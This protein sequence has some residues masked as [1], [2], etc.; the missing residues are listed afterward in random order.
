[1]KI[2]IVNTGYLSVPPKSAGPLVGGSIEL[3]TYHLVNE[4]ANLGNEVH[5]VTN[6]NENAFFVDGVTLH[7]IPDLSP[8][9][10]KGDY[11]KTL[12]S[13]A[14][15]GC[16]AYETA[17]RAINAHRYD[18]IHVHGNISGA[19]LP[20]LRKRIK[21]VF[22]IHNRTPWMLPYSSL[23]QAFRKIAFNT[24]DL[25]IIC[26]ADRV[27]TLSE[28]LKREIVC[29]FKICPAKIKVIPNGVDSKFF[30]P[31][32]PNSASIRDKYEINH[33]YVLFVGR[34]VEEKAVHTLLE[35]IAGTNLHAVIVGD[36]PLL[37]F[38]RSLATH[39]RI[40]HQVNFI[41]LVP[42]S[43]LPNFYAQAALFVLPSIA[44]GSPLAGFEAM[45]SGLP[46]V[47]SRTSGMEDIV[48]ASQNGIIID[49]KDTQHFREK[50]VELF[51]NTSLRRIMGE[52]SRKIVE[53][54]YSWK[55]NARRTL[56]LYKTID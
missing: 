11:T 30:K 41:G 8:L 48:N 44:E 39:L 21:C 13:F 53:A 33:D 14:I 55:E 47:A 2:L 31:S 18:L 37:P 15:G 25:N 23:K 43:E 46:I 27:I 49:P 9:S 45:A 38:L 54:Q 34:L 56:E 36:G 10:T 6:I 26:S 22:T 20:L 29:R 32:I 35:A 5:Y 12:V 42:R 52:R 28:N 40:D 7:K 4:L 16:L 19:F 3:H 24:L 17:L 1:M 50:L 51:K